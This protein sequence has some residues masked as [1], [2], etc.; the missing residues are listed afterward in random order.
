[1]RLASGEVLDAGVVVSNADAAWTYKN[2]VPASARRRW[3]DVRIDR[4]RYS[5]GLFVWYF[6]TRRRY[7]DVAH[8]S[9]LRGP[10]YRALLDDIFFRKT[11]ADDFS[12]YLHRPTATDPALA[13]EGCDTFYV[14]SPVPH[15]ESG[16][17][18]AAK[19]E[20]YRRAIEAK[21]EA[22]LLPGLRESLVVS[23]MMTPQHF[24]DDLLA[25][26]R[27]AAFGMEPILT[28]SAWF[29]PHNASEDVQGL[30]LVGA[31]THPGAGVSPASSS[32]RARPRR[33][34]P[35][36]AFQVKA[37]P[38]DDLAPAASPSCARGRRA[39]PP[40]RASCLAASAIPRWPS[41]PSC[42]TAD[43]AVDA[44]GAKPLAVDRLRE[45][46]ARVYAGCAGIE[47]PVERA[48]ASVVERFALSRARSPRR[49][50][51]A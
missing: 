21:L 35:R 18:W 14:L 7:P 29:R 44:P 42:R 23:E 20:P 26:F 28:Q 5:M 46:I 19:A 50:P 37:R 6:G 10:R 3:T 4:A 16:T 25:L 24:A 45:R 8:H 39:S 38:A 31:G 2:L 1:M 30:Y 36:G 13:P 33:D 48:F 15:L 34:R 41:T 11:L 27:G 9:I 22:T 40:P 43:D 17:D 51:R 47:G 49:S 32:S 12:L